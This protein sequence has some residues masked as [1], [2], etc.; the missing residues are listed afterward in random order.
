VPATVSSM[1]GL[2]HQLWLQ[3]T[4]WKWSVIEVC[5]FSS[6][7]LLKLRLGSNVFVGYMFDKGTG[8]TII[9]KDQ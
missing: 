3:K 6:A 9:Y 1:T 5:L 7:C 4:C 2:G 8:E